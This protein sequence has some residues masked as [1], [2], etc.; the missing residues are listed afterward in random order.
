MGWEYAVLSISLGT[1]L[2]LMSRNQPFPEQSYRF[3][4]LLFG[5]GL[6]G[7]VG[8]TA[9]RPPSDIAWLTLLTGTGGIGVVIGMRHMTYTRMDVLI[10]PA[11]GV[12]LCVGSIG[13]LWL[14][15]PVMSGFEQIASFILASFLCMGEVYLVFRGLLIG[16][17]PQSWSQAGLRNLQRGLLD[18]PNGAISCFERAWDIEKEHLNPMAYLALQRIHLARGDDTQSDEWGQ[19]LLESGGESAVDPA[20]IAAIEAALAVNGLTISESE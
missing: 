18:G 1:V 13:L 19:R 4:L 15:W 16:K 5:I 11:A 8:E 3:G 14:E 20:W 2:L 17:L 12:L 6:I 10:A 9:P 7:L